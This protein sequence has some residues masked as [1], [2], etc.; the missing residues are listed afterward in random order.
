MTFRP[1]VCSALVCSFLYAAAA[2]PVSSG[3]AAPSS[4][5]EIQAAARCD[6]IR[7][8]GRSYVFYRY[9]VSCDKAKRLAKRVYRSR[10]DP[11]GWTCESGSNFRSGGGCQSDSANRFFGWHPYD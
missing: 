10:E 9:R 6:S 5:L 4:G 8:N 7:L 2:W 3:A 11:P 1:V